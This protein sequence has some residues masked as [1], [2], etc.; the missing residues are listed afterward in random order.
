MGCSNHSAI[1]SNRLLESSGRPNQRLS[2]RQM[3]S[4]SEAVQFNRLANPKDQPKFIASSYISSSSPFNSL[5]REEE[6]EGGPIFG[7]LSVSG[8][9][10]GIM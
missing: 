3:L 7:L 2:N 8:H 5:E 4:K 9:I 10:I 6:R 1:R